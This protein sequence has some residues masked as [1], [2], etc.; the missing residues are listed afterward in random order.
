MLRCP[1]FSLYAL[2]ALTTASLI[3]GCGDETTNETPAGAPTECL[4]RRARRKPHPRPT[5]RTGL[6]FAETHACPR[7]TEEL[8]RNLRTQPAHER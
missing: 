1:K 3:A 2:A 5:D 7:K 4:R 6:P 8:L